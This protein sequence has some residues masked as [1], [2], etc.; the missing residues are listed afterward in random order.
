MKNLNNKVFKNSTKN[1]KTKE[2]NQKPKKELKG[3]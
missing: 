1:Y 2:E 3:N